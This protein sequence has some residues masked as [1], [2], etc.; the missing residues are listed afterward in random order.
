MEH[1]LMRFR[2]GLASPDPGKVDALLAG[3]D[4]LRSMIMDIPASDQAEPFTCAE[5]VAVSAPMT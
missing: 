1:L 2:D 4:K 5:V 3:V